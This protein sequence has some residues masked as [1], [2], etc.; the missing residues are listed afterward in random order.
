MKNNFQ[1]KLFKKKFHEKIPKNL[2]FWP[3]K[4]I[5]I[6]FHSAQ[7]LSDVKILHILRNKK[8]KQKMKIFPSV[9]PHNQT[10][11]IGR[12]LKI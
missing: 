4:R 8:N 11:Y 3:P 12:R 7:N 6:T 10:I 1:E 2:E 5:F 9:P